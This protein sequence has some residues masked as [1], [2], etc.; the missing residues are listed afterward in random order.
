[1]RDISYEMGYDHHYL[2]NVLQNALHTTF[3]TILNEYRVSHARHLILTSE[4]TI[5]DI[6]FECGYESLCS[7]NRNFKSIV[8]VTPSQYRETVMGNNSN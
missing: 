8:G 7:F 1:M 2:S 3:R 6:A 5:S 4:K